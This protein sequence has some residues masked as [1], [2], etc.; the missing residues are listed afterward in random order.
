LMKVQPPD[1]RIQKLLDRVFRMP[2]YDW[3]DLTDPRRRRGRR[4]TLKHLINAAFGGLLANCP[5]LRD[6]ETMTE[7]MG[8]AGRKYVPRRVPDTTL[9]QVLGKLNAQELRAKHQAQVRAAW[10][11]KSL[12]PVGLP[13]GVV[14]IDGKGLGALEHDA[15]GTA[16]KAHRS[17]DGSPYWLTRALRAVLTSAQGKPCLDQMPVD[18]KTNEMA[19]FG[20]FFADLM[21]VYGAGNLFEVVTVDAG[22]VSRANADRV[23]AAN[24]GYVMALKGTQP[25]L[26]AEAKRLLGR[27]GRK[28]DCEGEVEV[29]Q[30]HRVQRR[31]YRTTD[32]AG[33]HGWSHLQQV[34]RVEQ[35]TR[36][37]EGKLLGREDRYFLTNLRPGRLTLAQTLLV[38]RWHWGV[39]NDCFWSLDTQ[40]REDAVPWCS[41]GLAVEVLS[42]LRL[43]AYN[44]LQFARRAHLRLRHPTDATLAPPPPWRRIF[45]WVRQAWRRPLITEADTVCG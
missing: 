3:S 31:L 10:R 40:W 9:W 17:H 8:P 38:V 15:E 4:W 21:R 18:G 29:Y 20:D 32:M 30:G 27:P 14:A 23:H 37:P 35:E 26:F 44:L 25:E 42:W 24:K 1:L 41:Q 19:T 34:W 5:T 6:V 36:D 43:M 39:E 45:D 7:E 12:T 13:C 16:Q 33:Y 22:M 2:A 28:P 11:S